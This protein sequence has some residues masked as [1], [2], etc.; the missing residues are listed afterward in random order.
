MQAS[1]SSLNPRLKD[2]LGNSITIPL[3]TQEWKSSSATPRRALLN[4]FGAAGSNVAL[5]LEEYRS[6]ASPIKNQIGRSSYLFNVSA[7]STQALETL[8]KQY[9]QYLEVMKPQLHIGDICYTATARRQNYEHRISFVCKSVDDLLKQLSS[10]YF[11]HQCLKERAKSVVF[12]FSGQG[13]SY[14]GMGK[15]LFETSPLFKSI[16]QKSNKF[17]QSLGFPD[18]LH[19][20]QN[21]GSNFRSEDN[22][23]QVISFQ[24]ACVVVEYALAKLWMSWNVIPDMLIGHR[25]V[26]KPIVMTLL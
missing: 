8:V 13:S 18:I 20:L 22:N 16:I 26:V 3:E 2:F 10:W 24:C 23:N 6:S 17:I 25:Y 19:L 15:E 12:I 21:K 14:F 5:L 4:N 7:R 9:R 1:L 11:D